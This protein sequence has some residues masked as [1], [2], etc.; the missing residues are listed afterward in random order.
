MVLSYIVWNAD[1]VIFSIGEHGIRWYGVLLALG[2]LLAYLIMGKTMRKEGYKQEIIDKF[3]IYIIVGCI[4]GLRLGHCLFYNPGYYLS[5]PLEILKVW[6]GGLASHGGAIGIL[7]AI[8]I[9]SRRSKIKYFEL[10]DKVALIVPLAGAFV[11]C[12]NF[13][14]SEILGIPTK[15]PWGV[16]F[17]RNVEDFNDALIASNGACEDMKCLA[18]Y[19]VARH[20]TQLYEALFYFA[21]FGFFFWIYKKY[22][23]KWKNGTFLGWFVLVLFVFRYLIEFT[24]TEQVEFSGWTDMITMGQLLSVPFILFGLFLIGREY[25]WWCKKSDKK[26]S[27]K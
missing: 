6:E 9:Y 26:P 17:L 25:G 4:I 13:I 12:G 27:A 18:D 8:W 20:P 5:H 11:R 1:P 3:S 16:K 24:K 23:P 15:M 21:M 10:M 7:I 22:T 19:W 14:N 2:F